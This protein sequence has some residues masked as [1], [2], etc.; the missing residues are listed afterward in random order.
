MKLSGTDSELAAYTALPLNRPIDAYPEFR[1][2]QPH[3]WWHS[4][5]AGCV[6]IFVQWGTTGSAVL[7][8]YLT[9]TTVCFLHFML[10]GESSL[11]G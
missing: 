9:P 8:A 11:D 5:V 6:S 1:N 7:I 3:V 4:V 10:I 2:V